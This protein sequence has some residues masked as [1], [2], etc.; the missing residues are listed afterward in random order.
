MGNTSPSARVQDKKR[1]KSTTKKEA[2]PQPIQPLPAVADSKE[3][4]AVIL[5]ELLRAAFVQLWRNHEH[6]NKVRESEC[7]FFRPS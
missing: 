4:N 1:R 6:I 3:L 5:L 2:S 7:L